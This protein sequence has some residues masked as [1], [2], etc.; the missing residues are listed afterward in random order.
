[1]K[2]IIALIIAL[3]LVM[4]LAITASA[5]SITITPP[6]ENG[7]TE[8]GITY[9]AYKIFD[10]AIVGDITTAPDVA[11]DTTTPV[12]YTISATST[13]KATL[14]NFKNGETNVFTFEAIPG[15]DSKLNVKVNDTYNAADLAAH[16][17]GNLGTSTLTATK[18]DNNTYKF[19]GLTPGYYLITSSVGSAIVVDT[20]GTVSVQSKNE[21]PT[22]SKEVD[23]ETADKGAPLTFTLQISIPEDAVGEIVVHDTMANVTYTSMTNVEGITVADCSDDDCSK[24]FTLSA[25]YVENNKGNTITITYTGTF[26][27]NDIATNKA[28]LVDGTFESKHAEVE[29]LTTDI[30]IY[31]HKKDEENV[32]LS[33]AQFILTK[34]VSEEV[35]GKTSNTTYYYKSANDVVSWVTDKTHATVATTDGNGEAKFENVADG[36]YAL[37]ET[38]APAGYNLLTA[39][40]SVTVAAVKTG[41]GDNV[42]VVDI[43]VDVP[44]STGSELPSTG[45]IGTTLFYV[46][47]GLLM[48]GAAVLLITKK[49]MSN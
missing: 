38:A 8:S 14:E 46:I 41:E 48:T 36:T 20:L 39:P 11:P 32:K 42:T 13:Y 43:P 10:A 28:Y 25:D 49:R 18:Q 22:L 16:M 27:A 6:D 37:V 26:N 3:A 15:D 47:G 9:T 31:K 12:S 44:N 2:K 30:V 40:V 17:A 19:E 24:T 7:G 23:K 5:A 29:I 21:Y 1:M 4:G 34:T 33:G 45:G 35:N